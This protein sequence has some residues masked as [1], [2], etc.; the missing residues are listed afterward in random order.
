[1]NEEQAP[2]SQTNV[3]TATVSAGVWTAVGWVLS[4][5]FLSTF[6]GWYGLAPTDPLPQGVESMWTGA[7]STVV[8]S[9]GT[10][11]STWRLP[12]RWRF[13]EGK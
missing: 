2:A 13:W 9:L 7:V 3:A 8:G 10:A 12:A 4:M 11:L 1:M 5:A 6:K